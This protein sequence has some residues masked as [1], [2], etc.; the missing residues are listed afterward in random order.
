VNKYYIF[1]LIIYSFTMG[2]VLLG[3]GE[4]YDVSQWFTVSLPDEPVGAFQQL[5]YPLVYAL[6]I[7]TM[8][9]NIPQKA[10]L[11]LALIAETNIALGVF[12]LMPAMLCVVAIFADLA[13]LVRGGG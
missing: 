1:F 4:T 7:L 11:T 13:K 5:I 2:F 12:I 3:L 9:I 8:I 10:F 6:T